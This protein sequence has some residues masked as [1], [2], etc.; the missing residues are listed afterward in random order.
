MPNTILHLHIQKTG[1][2]SFRNYLNKNL[3]PAECITELGNFEQAEV[4]LQTLNSMTDE[5]RQSLKIIF[6]HQ[7]KL[8]KSLFPDADYITVFRDP[9]YRVMS[10]Y[11][12]ERRN[13]A[14]LGFEEGSRPLPS[15]TSP[16][17]FWKYVLDWGSRGNFQLQSR[18]AADFFDLDIKSLTADD[19]PQLVDRFVLTG[20]LEKYP[21]FIFLMHKIYGF[22][23][24]HAP[25][26]NY[27]IGTQH[28]YYP[29]WFINEVYKLSPME[30]QLYKAASEKLDRVAES[31]FRTSDVVWK[32]WE[33]YRILTGKRLDGQKTF[34]G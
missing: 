22:P 12:Y 23:L 1:G 4:A 15:E 27:S 2:D 16:E 32:Q 26:V 8:T 13:I 6:G 34:S 20:V 30:T 19:M 21:M 5:Q 3:N 24:S 33:D 14:E 17:S 25:M 11:Y 7:V 28:Q 9:F 10:Q 29:D 31:V 18:T